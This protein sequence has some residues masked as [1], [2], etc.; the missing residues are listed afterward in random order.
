MVRGSFKENLAPALEKGAVTWQGGAMPKREEPRASLTAGLTGQKVWLQSE[1]FTTTTEDE[2]EIGWLSNPPQKSPSELVELIKAERWSDIPLHSPLWWAQKKDG[3]HLII[4]RGD[5]SA[6]LFYTRSSEDGLVSTDLV[7]LLQQSLLPRELNEAAVRSF[8]DSGRWPDH[9]LPWSG[10][11]LLPVGWLIDITAQARVA[12][13]YGNDR[14]IPRAPQPSR[15]TSTVQDWRELTRL[16]QLPLS[17]PDRLFLNAAAKKDPRFLYEQPALREIA[18]GAPFAARAILH[19]T[20]V[21]KQWQAAVRQPKLPWRSAWRALALEVWLET[22]FDEE[23]DSGKTP[24][25]RSGAKG[26]QHRP[27]TTAAG[28]V[29][30]WLFSTPRVEPDTNLANLLSQV[31]GDQVPRLPTPTG[32]YAVVISEKI[33][34]ITQGRSRFLWDIIPGRLA[35]F[36]SR[37]VKRTPHGIGLGSPWTMQLALEEVGAG[38]IILA[39]LASALT[40]PLGMSGV[41]YRVAGRQAAA[42]DGP[43]S[44]SLYP[45][46]ISAKLAPAAPAAAARN[47]EKALRRRLTGAWRSQLKGVVII[48]ANDLGQEVLGNTTP[49]P[50]RSVADL[51]RDN[52]MGQTD[53]QTPLA[54]VLWNEK[55]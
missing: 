54:I 23:E 19:P 22:F 10:A 33:V 29:D 40:K 14:A 25:K 44:Y 35:L 3:A 34:A 42:I 11:Y 26:P 16:N 7:G 32:P 30:R 18:C 49:W 24:R 5:Q 20:E 36:L 31:L 28:P 1:G 8:I 13:P 41:F 50:D 6:P 9:Q 55:S 45:S 46:N 39:A 15:R 37:Y 52:P 21:I 12:R 2:W 51:F 43:T 48:D 27:L 38:R 17:R 53:E 47:L 4:G